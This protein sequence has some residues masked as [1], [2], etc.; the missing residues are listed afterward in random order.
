[1][2]LVNP[3]TKFFEQSEKR[4][5]IEGNTIPFSLSGNHPTVRSKAKSQELVSEKTAAKKPGETI[6]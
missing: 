4:E 1:M 3:K 5:S 6:G 2:S